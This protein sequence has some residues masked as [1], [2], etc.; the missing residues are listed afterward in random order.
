MVSSITV[1]APRRGLYDI[2]AA[3]Q[4]ALPTQAPVSGVLHL[5]LQHT[6]ASLI[7]QENADPSVQRDLEDWLDRQVPDGDPRYRHDAEG[8][9]DMPAHIKGAITATEM[10]LP[11]RNGRLQL[12]TWQG[13]FL[14]EHRTQPRPRTLL[15]TL[16]P[17]Q[18]LEVNA[19]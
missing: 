16:L 7:V 8:P 19:R 5:F 11:V 3:V 6:S 17:G 18:A 2:T 12:G 1:T 15:L 13:L 14:W 4:R 10:L 9:D